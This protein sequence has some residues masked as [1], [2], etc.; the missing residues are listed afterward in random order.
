MQRKLQKAELGI[1]VL[2][3]MERKDEIHLKYCAASFSAVA[4][5]KTGVPVKLDVKHHA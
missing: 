5:E 2:L 4:A 3:G 1:E